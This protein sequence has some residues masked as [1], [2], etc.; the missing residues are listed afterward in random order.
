M[1]LVSIDGFLPLVPLGSKMYR[2]GFGAKGQGHI[3]VAEASSTHPC[4]QLKLSSFNYGRVFCCGVVWVG[5]CA[6][7]VY[8]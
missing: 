6:L 5:L 3:F 2:L 4:R 7:L 8:Q 1:S